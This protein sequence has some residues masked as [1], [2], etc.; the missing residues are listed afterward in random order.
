MSERHGTMS[1]T[2]MQTKSGSDNTKPLRG[3]FTGVYKALEARDVAETTCDA[4]K[5][6]I[7][8]R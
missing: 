8:T 4:Y 1:T 3:S 5:S 7:V 2:W 6:L